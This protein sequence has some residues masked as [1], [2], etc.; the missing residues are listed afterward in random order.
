MWHLAKLLVV[1][2]S[3]DCTQIIRSC[4]D[5]I[6]TKLT[7]AHID[8]LCL[9]NASGSRRHDLYLGSFYSINRILKVHKKDWYCVDI[10]QYN[11]KTI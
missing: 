4:Q 1:V 8:Y 2:N 11:K 10:H 7:L 5:K 3:S 9:R 6:T